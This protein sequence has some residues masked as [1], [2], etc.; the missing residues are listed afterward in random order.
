[1]RKNI[2]IIITDDQALYREIA[3]FILN[4]NENFEVIKI[5]ENGHDAVESV[6]IDKPDIMLV[7][8]N[9]KPMS[10]FEVTTQVKL[11]A[12]SV[13][14]I[15][16]TSHDEPAYVKHMF[17]LGA[18]GFITK[19]S[20]IEEITKGIFEVYNGNDYIC[21]EMKKNMAAQ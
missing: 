12:P 20:T 13:K 14:V 6:K 2:R 3:K 9:M 4:N 19:T 18:N 16:F 5:C 1:M 11:L 8:I 7:D 21:E 17:S 15:A 10:G